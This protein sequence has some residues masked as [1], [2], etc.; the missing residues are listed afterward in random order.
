MPDISEKVFALL[1]E[2]FRPNEPER[3]SLMTEI[4]MRRFSWCLFDIEKNTF[5][6]AGSVPGSYHE[7]VRSL[8]WIT[9]PFH[10][11]RVIYSNGRSTLIPSTLFLEDE[12][13]NYF[14]F[15][16]EKGKDDIV[17]CDRLEDLGIVNVYAM[18]EQVN[19]DIARIF[20]GS[21]QCH[22]SSV[23]IDCLYVNYKN[24]MGAGKMFLNIRE[25]EFDLV[26]FSGKQLRYSNSFPFRVPE[27]LIY[28]VIFVMEQMNLNPEEIPL[29][30][31]GT[32]DKKSRIFEM[33]FRYVRTVEF[34]G[35][36]ETYGYSYIMDDLPGHWYY[37]LFNSE[38]CGL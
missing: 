15:N 20:P 16:L 18:P 1:D 35:R 29:I 30:L 2:S 23:L 27:D 10:S 34:A 13:E 19:S 31:L 24:L 9:N 12:I 4:E 11:R 6:G 21:K 36:N 25:E 38:Q 37:T 33:L 14:S 17:L 7:A 8:S 32:T 28:Y 5:I 3:Y 26:I 22:V